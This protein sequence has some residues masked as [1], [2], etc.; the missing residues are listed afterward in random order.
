MKKPLKDKTTGFDLKNWLIYLGII[1]VKSGGY[2]S[3][4]I[5]ERIVHLSFQEWI[6]KMR[7]YTVSTPAWS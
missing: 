5:C 3:M 1:Y 4:A 7:T 6:Q 2:H